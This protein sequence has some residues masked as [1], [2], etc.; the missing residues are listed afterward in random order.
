M[1][2]VSAALAK[3]YIDKIMIYLPLYTHT[4]TN[5]SYGI[6]IGYNYITLLYTLAYNIVKTNGSV[7]KVAVD[8]FT[9]TAQFM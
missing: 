3:V 4:A 2:A 5:L 8:Y 6:A 1:T 7:L 9:V